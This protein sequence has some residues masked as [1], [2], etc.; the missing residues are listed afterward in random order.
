VPIA[1]KKHKV[2]LA[3]FGEPSC[4]GESFGK[5]IDSLPDV[6]AAGRFRGAVDAIVKA[7]RRSKPVIFCMGGHLVKCG[8]SRVII[9]L[10]NRGV[11]TAVA[12]NGAGSI[13]DFEIALI[14]RTSED[15]QK[16]LSDGTFGMAEETGAMVHEALAIGDASGMGAGWAIGRYILEK[17]LPH[18]NVSILAQAVR[19]RIPATVHIAIGTDTIHQHPHADGAVMGQTSMNDFKMFAEVVAGLGGGGVIVNAGSAVVMPEVFLKALTLARNTGRRVENFTAVALDMLVQYRALE[20]V[21]ERPVAEGGK[22]YYLIG[23]HE[24]M[25]PLLARAII[26]KI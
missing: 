19:L 9:D 3:M 22:G 24:I 11:I 25:V 16:G 13:H 18:R 20:N 21:V 12:T 17:K 26:E 6:L 10:M 7:H 1:R 8:L 15:V 4:K 5:F 2:R 23:H 14:G